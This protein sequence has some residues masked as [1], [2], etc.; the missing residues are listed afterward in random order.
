M[1]R[2]QIKYKKPNNRINTQIRSAQIRL[3]GDNVK[4]DV[5]DTAEAIRMADDM[6]MDLVEISPNAD[7][8]VCKIVEYKKFLYQ[9]KQKQKDREKNQHKTKVKE[10]RF[11]PNTD[12]NDFKFKLNHAINF[13]QKGN[14]VK[15]VVFFK[16]RMIR[17]KEQGEILLLR[18]ASAL[19]EHGVSEALPKLEGKRMF[20]TVKPSKK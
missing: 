19:E 13:L 9:Q 20:M 17:Y 12:D 6:G 3:V 7:P 1:Q 15:A 5:Y 14:K 10:L 2:K 8:P 18:L 16:G 4:V 11:T